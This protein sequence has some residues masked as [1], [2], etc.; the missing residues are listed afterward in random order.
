MRACA[1][2]LAVVGIAPPNTNLFLDPTIADASMRFLVRRGW[3]IGGRQD[4]ARFR[5][6]HD[7]GQRT[8]YLADRAAYADRFALSAAQREALVALDH[9]A[10]VAM[11]THP[12]LPFL[13][14][15]QADRAGR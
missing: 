4:K 6:T 3:L 5:R 12:L 9:K 11:G 10:I 7:A 8:A 14:R 2:P 13:A 1:Q 15:M